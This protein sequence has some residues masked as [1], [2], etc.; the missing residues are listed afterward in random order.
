MYGQER[1]DA[2]EGRL[3]ALDIESL[4]SL[5]LVKLDVHRQK[6]HSLHGFP[7]EQVI[8]CHGRNGSDLIRHSKLADKVAV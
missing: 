1:L 5:R 8:Q 7:V 3:E 2:N 4:E 6:V